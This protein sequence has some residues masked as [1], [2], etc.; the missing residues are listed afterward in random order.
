MMR[1]HRPG[2]S[3]QLFGNNLKFILVIAHGNIVNTMS[4]PRNM[5]IFHMGENESRGNIIPDTAVMP[6]LHTIL[7]MGGDQFSTFLERKLGEGTHT[8]NRII[9]ST[10]YSTY[11]P[12]QMPSYHLWKSGS[13]DPADNIIGVFDITTSLENHTFNPYDFQSKVDNRTP[14]QRRPGTYRELT[15]LTELLKN[16]SP[17]QHHPSG[18]AY[19][20]GTSLEILCRT[21]TDPAF[22]HSQ[23][24]RY[25]NGLCFMFLICCTAVD[26]AL[27]SEV[28]SAV[29]SRPPAYTSHSTP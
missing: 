29:V 15:P 23:G 14:D 2:N 1:N 13:R 7:G 25:D 10:A 20:W 16:G 21:L 27:P 11:G 24:V 8:G 6:I 12:D 22:S 17:R 28:A 9:D 26:P 19:R 4:C 18:S 3:I 5:G